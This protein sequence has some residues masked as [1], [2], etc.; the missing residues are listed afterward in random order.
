SGAKVV[1]VVGSG[2]SVTFSYDGTTGA[3]T[4]TGGSDGIGYVNNR[5]YTFDFNGTSGNNCVAG[6]GVAN[7]GGV[8]NQSWSVSN[9]SLVVTVPT[10]TAY[11]D[12]RQVLKFYGGDCVGTTINLSNAANQKLS[13]KVNSS[14]ANTSSTTTRQLVIIFYNSDGSQTNY[15]GNPNI[16][17]LTTGSNVYSGNI[18]LTGITDKTTI[19]QL[20]MF[21]RGAGATPWN[22]Y[23]AAGTYTF[24][25]FAIG[26]ATI[27]GTAIPTSISSNDDFSANN[28]VSVY[29]N[30]A[31]DKFT[32]DLSSFSGNANVRLVGTAGNIVSEQNA[33]GSASFSLEGLSKGMY[34]VQIS[35]DNRVIRKK[36]MVD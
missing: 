9:G 5:A 28:Q 32:V 26:N 8:S 14:P 2:G 31:T 15:G 13:F 7:N 33:T 23:D 19:L 4:V 1:G 11:D 36:V 18:D 20:G 6:G 29:P 3:T 22:D 12:T 27:P 10:M 16:V 35:A 34:F 25:Y 21:V 17:T 30:P 24:E